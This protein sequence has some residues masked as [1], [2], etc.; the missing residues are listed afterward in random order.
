MK[1]MGC[2]SWPSKEL[3]VSDNLLISTGVSAN[4]MYCHDLDV[5]SLNPDDENIA[6]SM[7]KML[8]TGW[9]QP[10]R[11][12]SWAWENVNCFQAGRKKCLA[13]WIWRCEMRKWIV[14]ILSIKWLNLTISG[15][16][17]TSLYVSN[18]HI[19]P[20]HVINLNVLFTYHIMITQN[21]ME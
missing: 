18:Y 14:L 15:T 17:H 21:W 5:I 19:I 11:R 3:K 2:F 20:D 6:G 10:E 4:E 1:L 16:A 8:R 12:L 13:C 9:N 7:E